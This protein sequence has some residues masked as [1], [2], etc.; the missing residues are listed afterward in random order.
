MPE[1]GTNKSWNPFNTLTPSLACNR[2]RKQ[3]V[4]FQDACNNARRRWPMIL[5]RLDSVGASSIAYGGGQL[6]EAQ[7]TR[8]YKLIKSDTGLK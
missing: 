5:S 8:R 3:T 7:S 1:R 4:R 2:W 6:R